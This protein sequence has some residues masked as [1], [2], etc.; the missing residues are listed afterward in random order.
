MQS[1]LRNHASPP[2]H[3]HRLHRTRPGAAWPGVS[4]GTYW[5]RRERL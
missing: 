5:S 1:K 2:L 4:H 3:T